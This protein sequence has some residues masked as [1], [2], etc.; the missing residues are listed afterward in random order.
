MVASLRI[1]MSTSILNISAPF[2]RLQD[3]PGQHDQISRR[4][5]QMIFG[6]EFEVS[7]VKDGWAQGRSVLDGYEGWVSADNLTDE[8]I[9]TTH[10]VDVRMTNVYPEPDF[11]TYPSLTMTFM[12]RVKTDMTNAI[13]GFAP[14]V[15]EGKTLW[16]PDNHLIGLEDLQ[17]N[18]AD[19][20]DTMIMFK[21]T[22]YIYGGRTAWGVDCSALIQLALQRNGLFCP[23][24]TDQQMPVLGESVALADI[25][26]G[27]LVYFPG[28]VGAMVDAEN[29]LNATVREMKSVIEPLHEMAEYYRG[30][31]ADPIL[32]IRRIGPTP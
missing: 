5:S 27:D 16:V 10:A 12:S 1:F 32:D 17:S 14:I 20:V 3:R 28:H 18:P 26:R 9:D 6:E 30:N 21:D 8:K 13:G 23:R 31:G 11:K 25:K 19:T 7:H 2:A 22:S 24:D 15:H 29:I 4:D